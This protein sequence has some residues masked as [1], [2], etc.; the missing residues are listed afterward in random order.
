MK[1]QGNELLQFL[2]GLAMLVVG[3]YWFMQKVHVSSSWFRGGLFGMSWLNNGMVVIP[4]I[5]GVI[6]MFV[7]FDS[8]VAKLVAAMGLLII[9][10]SII[11]STRLTISSMTL[12]D[13]LLMLVFIFGGGGL[14]VKIL[15]SD[16]NRS[17]KK[18]DDQD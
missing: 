15:F 14:V 4:F 13:W 10:A 1:K 3:L 12:Y 18:R 5:I 7:D 9:I 17:S 11:A 8:F 16:P 2:A 6:W